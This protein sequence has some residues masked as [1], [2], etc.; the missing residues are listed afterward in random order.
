MQAPCAHWHVRRHSHHGHAARHVWTGRL[1]WPSRQYAPPATAQKCQRRQLLHSAGLTLCVL[2]LQQPHAAMLNMIASIPACQA[3][4]RAAL[5][6]LTRAWG[7]RSSGALLLWSCAW[8]PG[9]GASGSGTRPCLTLDWPGTRS[10]GACPAAM[11]LRRRKAVFST[12]HFA[13]PMHVQ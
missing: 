7:A 6:M 11:L 8:R 2:R 12:Q 5:Q 1:L 4:A 10:A 3:G 13:C 9:H